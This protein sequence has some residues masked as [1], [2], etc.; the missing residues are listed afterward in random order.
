MR[1][2]RIN[3]FG[4][5]VVRSHSLIALTLIATLGLANASRYVLAETRQV[6]A[7]T[8]SFAEGQTVASFE[9][10]E[11]ELSR[12][13]ETSEGRMA[14]LIGS[15]DLTSLFTVSGKKLTYNAKVLPLPLG[16]SSLTVYLISPAAEWK[17]IARFPIRVSNDSPANPV[18]KEA[19]KAEKPAA[20]TEIS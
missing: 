12:P 18:S 10:I 16:E 15:S 9:S 1:K 17:E 2:Q 4:W 6:L 5:A 13:V 8:A 20:S 11:L 7:V 19:P 3:L 14:V